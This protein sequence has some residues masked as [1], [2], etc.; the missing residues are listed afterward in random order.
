MKV[1]SQDVRMGELERELCLVGFGF[2][3]LMDSV[4]EGWNIHYLRFQGF[5]GSRVTCFF[6]L[7]WSRVFCHGTLKEEILVC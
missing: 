7:I 2:L 6:F 5:P 1:H 3:S 4:N